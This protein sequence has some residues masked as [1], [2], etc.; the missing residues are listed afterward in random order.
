MESESTHKIVIG[1]VL[2]AVFGVGVSVF[3]IRT[4][5]ENEAARNAPAP[6]PAALANQDAT[7]AAAAAQTAPAQSPPVDPAAVAS[8]TPPVA[9]PPLAAVSA[10]SNA[11]IATNSANDGAKSKPSDRADR[12]AA[13]ARNSGDAADSQITADV[14][15]EFATAAPN[16]T[17]DV[18]TTNGVVA[19]A[20]SVPSQD[21][22]DQARQAARRVS[23]V[24]HVDASALT[25][26]NQ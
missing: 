2:A 7:D 6:T 17:V 16:S 15:S 14:K 3:A 13:K 11:P 26:S 18:T 9:P 12:R 5:N 8:A 10:D 22:V 24:K 23:G 4:H 20:G 25:V 21:A 1:V 19:L